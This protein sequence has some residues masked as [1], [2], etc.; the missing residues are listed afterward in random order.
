MKV[1]RHSEIPKQAMGFDNQTELMFLSNQN[2]LKSQ[3]HFANFQSCTQST[4]KLGH[5]GKEVE[6]DSLKNSKPKN[7]ENFQQKTFSEEFKQ[8][9]FLDGEMEFDGLCFEKEGGV[10]ELECC[11]R[12]FDRIRRFDEERGLSGLQRIRF[13]TNHRGVRLV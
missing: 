13:S 1:E 3:V 9:E 12:V 4:N 7:S 10:F 11:L 5:F 8:L 6:S 2:F